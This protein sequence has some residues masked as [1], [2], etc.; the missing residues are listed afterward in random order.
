MVNWAVL[1]RPPPVFITN[2]PACLRDGC[3]RRRRSAVE[4]K[5]LLASDFDVL[6]EGSM[7]LIIREHA[8][9]YQLINAHK[10]VVRRKVTQ[11]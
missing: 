11:Q 10:I 4:L 6:E 1:M 9:K 7:P 8:R 5:A 3:S 2:P